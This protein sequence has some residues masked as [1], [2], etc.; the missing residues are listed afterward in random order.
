MQVDN[1][2]EGLVR[3]GIR[4]VRLGRPDRV[5][6]E[7]LAHC[8]DVPGPGRTE[9]NWSEKMAAIRGAEVTCCDLP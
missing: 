4:A 9:V 7:L 6:P 5:R 1:L 8:V 2:L 3:A